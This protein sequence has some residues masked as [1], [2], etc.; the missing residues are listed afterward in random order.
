MNYNC[1][2]LLEFL[3]IVTSN[4]IR[5]TTFGSVVQPAYIM[6]SLSLREFIIQRI[7]APA[8][9]NFNISSVYYDTFNRYLV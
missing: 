2:K 6:C 5:L 3:V 1:S 7:K 8:K 4:L 9:K